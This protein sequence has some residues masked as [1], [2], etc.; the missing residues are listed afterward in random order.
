MF[1]TVRKQ[2]AQS[3]C[4]L[5]RGRLVKRHGVQQPIE[6]VEALAWDLRKF[7]HR[8]SLEHLFIV[9]SLWRE[10]EAAIAAGD[11]VTLEELR[12]SAPSM[13]SSSSGRSGLSTVVRRHIA[14][15]VQS[16]LPSSD[17]EAS[18]GSAGASAWLE[19]TCEGLEST[20]G[21]AWAGALAQSLGVPTGSIPFT[22]WSSCG[23]APAT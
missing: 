16:E 14:I 10:G 2:S 19:S 5:V 17:G 13:S 18:S 22:A 12:L 20:C 6:P 7:L 9:Q 23:H 15:R 21:A 1:S 8:S 11:Y 4:Q 3:D